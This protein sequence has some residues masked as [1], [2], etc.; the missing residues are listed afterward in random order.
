MS[1]PENSSADSLP[2]SRMIDAEPRC[3][4]PSGPQEV[5]YT[6]FKRFH[7]TSRPERDRLRGSQARKKEAA[8]EE[9]D[10]N[11]ESEGVET[12]DAGTDGAEPE[13]AET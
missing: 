2:T 12:K 4:K 5:V 10:G 8:G 9:T 11:A 1:T 7:D 3:H 6:R 13:D